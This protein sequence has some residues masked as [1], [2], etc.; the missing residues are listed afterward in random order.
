MKKQLE[1]LKDV[2]QEILEHHASAHYQEVMPFPDIDMSVDVN[3]YLNADERGLLRTYTLRRDSGEL[4]GY[5]I[6]DLSQSILSSGSTQAVVQMIYIQPKC[7]AAGFAFVVWVD[8]Q[9]RLEK[10]EVVYHQVSTL[11]DYSP[12]L[13]RLGYQLIQLTFARRF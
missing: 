12:L 3:L 11:R 13:Q 7:R 4:V 6:V 9:L 1:R 5:C 2:H 10:V 8:E